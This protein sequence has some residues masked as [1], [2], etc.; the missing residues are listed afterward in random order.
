[1]PASRPSMKRRWQRGRPRQRRPAG[2]QAADRPSRRRKEPVPSDQVNLTDEESASCRWRAAASSSATTPRPRSRRAVCWWS[3]P[4]W[5]RRPTTSSR[6]SRCWT[7]RR[8]A[9]GTGQGRNAA[10]RYRLFQ[11]S[12]RDACAAPGDRPDDREGPAVALST[13]GG[14]LRPGTT[15]TAEPDTGRS[16]APPPARRP[17]ARSSMPCASRRR[18][19]CSG[20]SNR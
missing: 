16:H 20:S 5:S 12:Q 18:N 1:M 15:G 19:P 14:A 4:M 17:K 3:P 13:A 9:G 11:R 8:P 10:G 2:S 7:A 6:S